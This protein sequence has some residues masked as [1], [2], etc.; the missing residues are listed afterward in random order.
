[1]GGAS[2]VVIDNNNWK[3]DTM[4]NVDANPRHVVLDSNGHLFVSYNLLGKIACLEAKTGKTLFTTPTHGK[5]RTII[6]SKN[7]QFLFATCYAS[8]TLDVFRINE[9]SFTKINSLPCKGHPVG[10]DIFENNDLLEAWVCSY[11]YG[12]ISVFSFRKK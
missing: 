1:M 12:T 9:N 3:K 11:T 5:P 7:Q 10:I 8:D 6:L 4:L 2:I